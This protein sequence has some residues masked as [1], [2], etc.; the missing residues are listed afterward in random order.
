QYPALSSNGGRGGGNRQYPGFIIFN[1]EPQ[2]FTDFEP[3]AGNQLPIVTASP[4]G[5]PD[6]LHVLIGGTQQCFRLA[7]TLGCN[8]T[9]GMY[10]DNIAVA[11]VDQP[12]LPGQASASS[13]VNLGNIASD[14]WQFAND[15]FPANETAGLPGTAAFD[16]TAG[17][18]RSGLN[19][20]Q[21]TGNALRFDI[22]GDSSVTP[23]ANATVG[24]AD[25]PAL[26]QVRV[27]MVFRI[28]PGPGNYRIA[29]GRSMA[30]GGNAVTGVLLQVPQNQAAA[31]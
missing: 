22:P 25:D 9:D 1:P 30:P 5:L 17:K 10:F 11:F 6:S 31:A 13:T 28:L 20:A 21:A 8:W 18:I 19:N 29:G 2:C 3:Y 14:I 4:D 7:V 12:G 23:A 24:T 27:D 26:V 15:T 16:T